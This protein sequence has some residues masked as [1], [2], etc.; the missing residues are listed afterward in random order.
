MDFIWSLQF[1]SYEDRNVNFLF[2]SHTIRES[3][4][5]YMALYRRPTTKTTP[6]PALID[7]YIPALDNLQIRLPL[8][9]L[10]FTDSNIRIQHVLHCALT[11]LDRQGVKPNEWHYDNVS[12]CW[13]FG[14]QNNNNHINS[15][16]EWIPD[17]GYLLSPHLIEQVRRQFFSLFIYF[18]IYKL[19]TAIT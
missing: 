15:R 10:D 14:K 16:V 1:R 12:M 9:D 18:I 3:Q 2:V 11:L 5:W 4:T 6:I 13:R 19:T 7:L 17:D 8:A